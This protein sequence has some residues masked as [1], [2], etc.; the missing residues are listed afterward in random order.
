M[1]PAHLVLALLGLGCAL[2]AAA[3]ARTPAIPFDLNGDGRQELVVGAPGYAAGGAP[4][5]GAV[6]I[7]PGSRSGIALA[8]RRTLT[9]SSRGVPGRAWGDDHFG[10]QLASS[11]FNRDGY[12]DLAVAAEGRPDLTVLR[13][14]RRGLTAR[15]ARVIALRERGDAAAL[16]GADF[17]R[18]GFGDLA[19]GQPW[20]DPD[21]RDADSE[22][23]GSGAI[24]VLFGSPRGLVAGRERI[25]R[26]RSRGERNFGALLTAGDVTGDGYPELIEG[27]RGYPEEDVSGEGNLPGQ[28]DY[29]KGGRAGPSRCRP[30]PRPF[31][32]GPT[33]LAVGDVNGDGYG[34][35]VAGFAYDHYERDE[36]PKGAVAVWSGSRSGLAA[37][38]SI[39]RQGVAGIPGAAAA[40]DGFG[41]TVDVARIDADRPADVVVAAPGADHGNG[42]VTVLRGAPAGFG[43][44]GNAVYDRGT[45]SVPDAGAQVGWGH[46]LALLDFSGDRRAELVASTVGLEWDWGTLIALPNSGGQF[47]PAA[48]RLL[49]PRDLGLGGA[50][51][52]SDPDVLA[53]VLG[54]PSSSERGL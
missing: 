10:G 48:S 5:S 52:G 51:P 32:P 21:R 34:D 39:V 53:F 50:P 1:R 20:R 26:R 38:P 36:T 4:D 12:A 2:P 49:G 44:E 30:L 25:V 54:R 31:S 14:S 33:S 9:R 35:L 19:V 37:R 45:L 23:P 22:F 15:S 41:Q 47:D 13:G 40:G 8:R 11:D 24:R 42:H 3:A 16:V 46:S 17:N 27:D 28:L 7:I 29:C 6:V 18:D 43:P